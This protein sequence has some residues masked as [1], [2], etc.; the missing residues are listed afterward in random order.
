L[1]LVGEIPGFEEVRQH[2][3]FIGPTGKLADTLLRIASIDPSTVHFTNC[4]RC[5]LPRGAKPEEQVA[6]K[7]AECCK[8]L[9]LH[10]LREVEPKSV[11]LLGAV[12][13]KALVGLTGITKYRGCLLEHEDSWDLTS[14]FHPAST[15]PRKMRKA[16]QQ[17][18]DLI[19]Y[20]LKKAWGLSQGLVKHWKP[21][22]FDSK[23]V[24]GLLR[25][26]S[27]IRKHRIP[28]ALDVETTD[29]IRGR[30]D[31]WSARLET[32]GVAARIGEEYLAWSIPW[33]QAYPNYYPVRSGNQIVKALDQLL[34][35]PKQTLVFHNKLFDVP[36][37]ERHFN[38]PIDALCEDTLI[39]HHAVYPKTPHNLQQV[40]SQ[41]LA[42]PPWKDNFKEFEQISFWRQKQVYMEW[43]G[44]EDQDEQDD[45]AKRSW[46]LN[47]DLFEELLHYNASDAAATIEIYEIMCQEAKH[48]GLWDVY[49]RDRR[50]VHYTLDWTEDGIGIDREK[51]R[52]LEAEYSKRLD[53][54]EIDLRKLSTL[55]ASVELEPQ[56]LEAQTECQAWYE[57]AR[58]LKRAATLLQRGPDTW[59]DAESYIEKN[60]RKL[61]EESDPNKVSRIKRGLVSA[62]AA[63]ADINVAR[64]AV[65]DGLTEADL[66]M[67]SAEARKMGQ[68]S[69]A[70]LRKLRQKPAA[71]TFNPRSTHHIREI[72]IRRGVIPTKVT[73]KTKLPS[74]SR[75]SLWPHQDDEFVGQLFKW[76]DDYKLYSTYIKNLEKKLGPDGRLHPVYK[77]HSTPSGRFGMSPAANTWPHSMRQMMIASEGCKIVGADYNALELRVVALLSGE[78][79]W[80]EIFGGD[81]K[82]HERMSA[83]YFPDEFPQIN[84]QWLAYEGTEEEKNKAFPRRKELRKRAK[85]VTFGDIYLASAETLYEQIRTKMPE[86][87]T[88]EQHEQ[89]KREVA[90]MQRV[91]RAATPT[92][93]KW[94]YM[95]SDIAKQA[96]CL[97]TAR[98]MDPTIKEEQGGRIRKWTIQPDPNE[99]ANHGVQGMAGDIFN[100]SARRLVE[101]L[102]AEDLYR[103]HVWIILPVHDAW[104]LEVDDISHKN[105]TLPEY[106]A[107]LLEKCMYTEISYK[108]PVTGATNTMRFTAEAKI[109]NTIAE[110]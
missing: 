109:G 104:Y 12:P 40:A 13:L 106:V 69:Q 55:P 61:S 65:A 41:Y 52:E 92:R 56:I 103:T 10:N 94:A 49:E 33:P 32:I 37:L 51:R 88:K 8:P 71:D 22:I 3:V 6:I 78:P 30:I 101:A 39:L 17:H 85:N 79:E 62:R 110:V 21:N 57:K 68:R 72:V 54:M 63:L 31:A 96:R 19:Y 105:G 84:E 7:A 50:L 20:D 11:C 14:S 74:V 43:E 16:P 108:S 80:I 81:G 60:E 48:D 53:E 9:V 2:T 93:M 15:F 82:L 58:E 77:L 95:Q 59:R 100:A 25:F 4:I 36:V 102:Q 97:K 23:D 5:G 38:R 18:L 27:Q 67:Q 35:D 24:K 47:Q 87:R 107:K 44:T 29:D 42:I 83:R 66:L 45:L 89:L 98:W 26:L 28:V 73:K 99:C 34:A 46:D 1:S 76:R 86:I 64:K 90:A 91:L 70:N 75:D